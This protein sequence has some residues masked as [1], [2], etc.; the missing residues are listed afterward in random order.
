MFRKSHKPAPRVTLTRRDHTGALVHVTF[1]DGQTYRLAYG[2]WEDSWT[3]TFASPAHV[4]AITALG[5]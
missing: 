4:A 1:D 2:V 5:H 3:G